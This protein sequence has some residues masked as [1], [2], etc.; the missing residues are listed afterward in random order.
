MAVAEN[1]EQDLLP[2]SS[3]P[4]SERKQVRSKIYGNEQSL[5]SQRN[6]VK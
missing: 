1:R 3:L 6:A 2:V 4:V 5:S